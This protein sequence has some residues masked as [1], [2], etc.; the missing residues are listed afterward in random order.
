MA[1]FQTQGSYAHDDLFA[2]EFPRVT[3]KETLVSGQNLTRGAVVGK[4]TTGGKLALSLSGAADGSQTPFA[5]LAE[6]C[7][8]SGGDKD[9]L[10]YLSGEFNEAALTIGTAHTADSIRDGL[11]DKSIYLK[12]NVAK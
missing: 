6:D 7:D 1:D 10:I 9:C 5:I 8:A 4:I 12:T 2:G 11:R 3:R